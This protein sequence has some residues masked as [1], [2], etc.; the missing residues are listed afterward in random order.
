MK[1]TA[2][3][4]AAGAVLLSAASAT[5]Q[6]DSGTKGELAPV[7]VL[8]SADHPQVRFAVV[9]TGE[10]EAI[11]TCRSPCELELLPGDYRL[12]AEDLSSGAKRSTSLHVRRSGSYYL[13]FGNRVA[14]NVGVALGVAGTLSLVAGLALSIPAGFSA[15]T[16][17]KRDQVGFPLT[18]VGVAAAPAGLVL[19]TC[20]RT[21]VDFTADA[22][23]PDADVNLVRLRVGLFGLAGGGLGLGARLQL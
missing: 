12:S 1:T 7:R 10:R 17:R 4:L 13:M 2:S 20:G 6:D 15:E 19:Y 14:S 8:I 5:A 21:R 3:V 16:Q 11:E 18:L 22:R 9:R 23:V